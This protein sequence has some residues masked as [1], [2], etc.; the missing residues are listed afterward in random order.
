MPRKSKRRYAIDLLELRVQKQKAAAIRRDLL[1]E[2][3]SIKD[4]TDIQ[5]RHVLKRIKR[6]RY[7]R[8]AKKYRT[9]RCDFDLEDCISENSTKYNDDEF[10]FNFR[11]TRESFHLLLNEM[12]TKEAFRVKSKYKKQRPVSFQLLVFLFRVGKEGTGG[13]AS[14]VAS[15]FKIGRGSVHN[16]VRR[17]IK[18]LHEIKPEVVHWPNNDE[19]EEM[20]SHLAALGF[21][22]C[23]GIIDGTLVALDFQPEVFHECYYSRKSVYALNVMIICDHRRRITYYYAGWP[24]STHDNRVFRNSK[25]FKNRMDYFNFG[26]YLLGDSAYSHSS[27]MVQSFK[28]LIGVAEL[29]PTE[30]FFNTMLAHVRI[31][32]EHC[33]GILKGRFGCLKRNNIRIRK[34]KKEIKHLVDLIGACIVLHNLLI[35][36]DEVDIPKRWYDELSD[37]IDWTLYDEEDEMISTVDAVG[38][39]RRNVVYNSIINNYY[40]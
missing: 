1:D 31:T 19:K 30:E 16:Y 2:E 40:I 4:F 34:G 6:S 36:Y 39:N 22:H 25:V 38:A 26:E 10:L 37:A 32:S 28:K 18:A 14:A 17:C 11:I 8:R 21:R 12:E 7:F 13:S 24:G 15:H 20:K 9:N 3:D 29:P 23:I 27:I 33:I 5:T 35:N